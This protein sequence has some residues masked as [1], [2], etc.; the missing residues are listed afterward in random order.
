MQSQPQECLEQ[1]WSATRAQQDMVLVGTL[2]RILEEVA[3][4]GDIRKK[5][6]QVTGF[7]THAAHRKAASSWMGM[8]KAACSSLPPP[9]DRALP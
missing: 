6:E 7:L 1:R 4:A 2:G 3:L 9:P 8:T 5:W